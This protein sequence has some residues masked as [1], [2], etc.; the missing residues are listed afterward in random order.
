MQPP[1]FL[2]PRPPFERTPAMTAAFDS[3]L[4][5]T[6]GGG[7][8]EYALPFPKWQFLTWLCETQ[9]VVLHGSPHLDLEQ[10]E[11]RLAID[12]KAFSNQRAIYA[13]TDGIFVLYFAILDRRRYPAMTLFNTCLQPRLPS[14]QWSDPLYFFSIT[15]AALLQNPWCAGAV[16]ILRR[17]AFVEEP[18]G[19]ANGVEFRLPQWVGFQPEQPV[20]KL[21]VAP[22]DFPFLGQIHGHDDEKLARLA[23]ADPGGFPWPG[24]LE[25]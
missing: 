10:V 15:H 19:Q 18:P 11:P 21:L 1:P 4:R 2:I 6:P 25:C 17:D 7:L 12:T 20:A 8:V 13:T 23:A 16:Y 3:L 24:A 5:A 14:A 9:P 22:E